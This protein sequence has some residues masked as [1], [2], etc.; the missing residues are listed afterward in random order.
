MAKDDI[1]AFMGAGTFFTGKLNFQGTVRIDGILK[2][3]I[4]TPALIVEDGAVLDG[5]IQMMKNAAEDQ[6]IL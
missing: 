6:E 3:K 2:G 1:N 4:K 5:T